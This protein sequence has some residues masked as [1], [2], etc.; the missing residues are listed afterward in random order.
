MKFTVSLVACAGMAFGVLLVVVSS[1]ARVSKADDTRRGDGGS[2]S[3]VSATSAGSPS[4]P[5]ESA[6]AREASRLAVHRAAIEAHWKE[7]DD[8]AW[9]K[10]TQASFLRGLAE[11]AASTKSAFD[12]VDC[13]SR[14]CVADLEFSSYETERKNVMPFLAHGY[15]APCG[16]SMYGP[17]P[18]DPAA[19]Y[20][21]TLVL[22]CSSRT[23]AG[24]APGLP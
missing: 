17:V 16:T 14:T 18:Q 8:P 12:R 23:D 10:P 4:A 21:L 19:P 2:P 3:R 13:R 20:K 22:D 1:R 11:V 7:P 24:A 15:G 5:P 6:E 9:S